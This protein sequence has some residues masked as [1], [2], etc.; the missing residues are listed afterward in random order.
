MSIYEIYDLSCANLVL[1]LF[2]LALTVVVLI[3]V[4]SK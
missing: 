4:W 3:V 2:T 1:N